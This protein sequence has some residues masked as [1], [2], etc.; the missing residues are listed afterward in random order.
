MIIIV[1]FDGVMCDMLNPL[2]DLHN[3]T[4]Q[5]NFKVE[6][7]TK[8][9][10]PDTMRNLFHETPDFFYNLKPIEN[11]IE[12][13]NCL[14]KYHKIVFATDADNNPDIAKQKMAWWKKYE[15][16]HSDLVVTKYKW[17]L[18][19]D[20]IIDDAVHHVMEFVD[21]NKRKQRQAVILDMPYNRDPN[22]LVDNTYKRNVVR[23][24]DWIDILA[25]IDYMELPQFKYFD[26]MMKEIPKQ[27]KA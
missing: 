4:Y 20:V 17:Y 9:K 8:W 23:A 19:G 25:H 18:D 21:W 27:E 13:I 16:D 15:L 5:T 26:T 2:V 24:Y 3:D 11:A 12:G 22:L 6:N 10:L 1:D 14:K 7:I